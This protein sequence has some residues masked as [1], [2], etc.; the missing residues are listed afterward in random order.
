MLLH[1]QQLHRTF[2]LSVG[3]KAFDR[4]LPTFSLLSN[5]DAASLS[6]P[7]SLLLRGELCIRKF[8]CRHEIISGKWL[9][10]ITQQ[11]SYSSSLECRSLFHPNRVTCFLHSIWWTSRFSMKEAA[12]GL[13]VHSTQNPT[14]NRINEK[15]RHQPFHVVFPDPHVPSIPAFFHS[16]V[17]IFYESS[18]RESVCVCTEG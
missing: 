18:R 17:Y 8:C 7:I 1:R 10:P 3:W 9:V 6:S 16:R 13:Q 14:L 5:T 15:G 4:R 11:N 12:A 2:I